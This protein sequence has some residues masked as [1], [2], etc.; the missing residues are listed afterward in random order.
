M[1]DFTVTIHV[2][3]KTGNARLIQFLKEELHV[4]PLNNEFETNSGAKFENVMFSAQVLGF[5]S[6]IEMTC[7]TISDDK[8]WELIDSIVLAIKKIE[9]EKM[10][11]LSYAS[12]SICCKMD[13][14]FV[15]EK[16]LNAA[17]GPAHKTYSQKLAW[18]FIGFAAAFL[19]HAIAARP[20]ITLHE[21]SWVVDFILAFITGLIGWIM[22]DSSAENE[23]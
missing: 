11:D 6:K 8:Q 14:S 10:A 5:N 4:N 1:H 18:A 21:Y 9:A 7:Q 12:K 13:D 19:L 23:E 16:E 15:Y 22:V 20:G 17:E 2:C 3:G